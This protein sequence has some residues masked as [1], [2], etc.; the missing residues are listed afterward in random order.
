MPDFSFVSRRKEKKRKE[1]NKEVK[2]REFPP[3]NSFT[4]EHSKHTL[5]DAPLVSVPKKKLK[6]N[7]NR[8]CHD[9]LQ[10]AT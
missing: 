8:E 4:D 9:F 10:R 3:L 7:Y 5:S 2:C 6:G 1:K